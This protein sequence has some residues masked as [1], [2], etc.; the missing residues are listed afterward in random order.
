[1]N[2][3][4]NILTRQY[5][6]GKKEEILKVRFVAFIIVSVVLITFATILSSIYFHHLNITIAIEAAAGLVMLSALVALARGNCTLAVHIILTTGFVALWTVLFL[7]PSPFLLT[8]LDSIVLVIALSSAMSIAFFRSRRPIVIYFILNAVMLV[9]YCCHLYAS[10]TLALNPLLEYGFDS[11][12]ALL[13]AFLVCF[14]AFK[15][16]QE[17]LDELKRE[18]SERKRAEQALL[19]SRNLLSDHLDSTPVGAIFWDQNFCVTDWNPAA[20]SIFG[21]TKAEAVGKCGDDLILPQ[22]AK[23]SVHKLFGDLTADRGGRRSVNENTT[24]DGK[25]ILCEWFNAPLKNSRGEIA[26]A[27][28]LV[29]DITEK[30]RIQELLIQS[31]KMMS[32]GGLAAGMAHEINNPLSGI[33]QY[34]Q[35]ARNR[36]TQDS[37][38]NQDTAKALGT[39]MATIR[40]YA[41]QREV[42][43]QLDR[44]GEAGQRAGAIIHNMLSFSRKSDAGRQRLNLKDL[45][46]RTLDLAG[47]DYD[48]KKKVNFKQ[49]AIVRDYVPDI[50]DVFG[51]PGKIQQV[52][53]NLLKNACDAMNTKSYTDDETPELAVRLRKGESAVHII[54]ADNGPGMPPE[55]C[56]QI[57][58]PFFT[59]KKD[60]GTGLGLSIS[61]AIIADDHG[62][63]LSVASTPGKGTWFTIRLPYRQSRRTDE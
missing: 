60:K 7:D 43:Q 44:I 18:L 36:L 24:K 38:P 41:G 21:Y 23:G 35:V 63:T 12:V 31:E 53:L 11:G 16:N 54:M 10:S 6:S 40:A 52:L 1:M 22:N 17:A 39:S 25:V 55:I 14:N 19:E 42:I 59:T 56:R 15:I 46:E 9:I 57:F 50:P 62:G 45:I 32:V 26:G 2:G 47:H 3:L 4:S 20:Q 28:S 37:R 34:A 8:R 27:A 13:F 48:L 58:V 5:N 49:I 61:H 30:T 29:N 33:L 51:E